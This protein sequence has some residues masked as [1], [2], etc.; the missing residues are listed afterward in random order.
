MAYHHGYFCRFSRVAKNPDKT[1]AA[2]Q[3]IL[4]S[5]YNGD[6]LV[7]ENN[8]VRLRIGCRPRPFA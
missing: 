4:W 6:A 3:F 7:Q 1:A 5:F 8:F 2:L